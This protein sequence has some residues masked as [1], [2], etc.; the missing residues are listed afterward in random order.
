MKAH[1][2]WVVSVAAIILVSP[3]VSITQAQ[4]GD[5]YNIEFHR[6]DYVGENISSWQGPQFNS[7]DLEVVPESDII[8]ISEWPEKPLDPP[9]ISTW[10][11]NGSLI[12]E[13]GSIALPAGGS[14][15][16]NYTSNQCSIPMAIRNFEGNTEVF[17]ARCFSQKHHHIERY[18]LDEQNLIDVE[19]RITILNITTVASWSFYHSIGDIEFGAGGYLW[20]FNGYN[21]W[22]PQS[23]DNHS[24]SGSILKFAVDSN[25]DISPAQ[26]S[27]YSNG[28][29]WG[30]LVFAKGVRMPWRAVEISENRWIFGDV[31]AL[32]L[33]EINQL[34]S[35]GMNFGFGYWGEG[36][37][38]ELYETGECPEGCE[39][40]SEAIIGYDHSKDNVGLI[41]DELARVYE[42][43]GY[44]VFVGEAIPS[45]SLYPEKFWGRVIY[46]DF[47]SGWLRVFDPDYPESDTHFGHLDGVVDM[48]ISS[49]GVLLALTSGIQV[50]NEAEDSGL[51]YLEITK[52]E[53]EGASIWGSGFMLVAIFSIVG[54][55]VS[56]LKD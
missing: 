34:N 35:S 16:Y 15:D 37:D 24:L 2:G 56:L 42:L 54:V 41:E 4:F 23:Q 45:S 3:S 21:N 22:A 30:E 52:I 26:D 33:E 48:E 20:V 40:I 27:P 36:M 49:D 9:I 17:V 50:A 8:L 19:S 18:N 31:G 7:M 32:N 55:F 53:E 29:D 51:W 5:D 14:V 38:S 12:E 25:G 10:K 43:Q 39:H 13:I 44:A 11:I 46:G 6:F 1:I 28:Q 47:P